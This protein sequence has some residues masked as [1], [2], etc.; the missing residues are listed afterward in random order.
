MPSFSGKDVTV[1]TS[2]APVGTNRGT[3]IAPNPVG[4]LLLFPSPSPPGFS[5]NPPRPWSLNE[6]GLPPYPPQRPPPLTDS[7]VGGEVGGRSEA[8]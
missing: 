3:V 6:V 5:P 7:C 8:E 4:S 1:M 2:S